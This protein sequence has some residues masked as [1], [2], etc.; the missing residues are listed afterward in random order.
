MKFRV[1]LSSAFVFAFLLLFSQN[2]YACGCELQLSKDSVKRQVKDAK[3]K[4]QAVFT[5][6]VLKITEPSDG[7]FLLVKIQVESNWKGAKDNEIVIVTGKGNGDCGYSFTVGQKYL[8]Y[9]YQISNNQLS[10]NICQRTELLSDAQ[11]DIAILEKR[12]SK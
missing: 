1:V 10:T 7:N 3:K 8:I 5:G 12:K 11:E 6:K 9:A 4:S 2:S